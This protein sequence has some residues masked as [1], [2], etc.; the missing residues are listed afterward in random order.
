MPHTFHHHATPSQTRVA[1]TIYAHRRCPAT[2]PQ[3][4]STIRPAPQLATHQNLCQHTPAQQHTLT[5]HT[6][7]RAG[8]LP[9]C[10]ADDVAESLACQGLLHVL[11]C[12]AFGLQVEAQVVLVTKR[13]E[14]PHTAPSCRQ[15]LQQAAR[16]MLVVRHTAPLFV[17]CYLAHDLTPATWSLAV[18]LVGGPKDGSVLPH[19]ITHLLHK[20]KERTQVIP[21]QNNLAKTT[22]PT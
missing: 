21:C 16:M 14:V 11:C 20:T 4:T 13:T 2:P 12:L 8:A 3:A 22:W 9:T 10:D 6:T 17:V 19:R 5:A 15:A 1:C 18:H 7:H